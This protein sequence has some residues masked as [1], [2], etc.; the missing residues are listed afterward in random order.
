M[1]NYFIGPAP[2]YAFGL[3]CFI[4]SAIRGQTLVLYL[5]VSAGPR[6]YMRILL[7]NYPSFVCFYKLHPIAEAALI[8]FPVNAAESDI[9][10]IP[11]CGYL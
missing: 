10:N 7:W 11:V 2:L 9:A 8:I 4:V 3:A 5:T 6:C 1:Q